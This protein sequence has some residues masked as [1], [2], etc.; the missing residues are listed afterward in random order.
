MATVTWKES[1][2][3]RSLDAWTRYQREHDVSAH[4][5]RTAGIDPVS[6]Q[7]WFGDSIED[8]SAQLQRH[9]ATRPLYFLRIGQDHY[10]R[11]GGHR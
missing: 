6:G 11:K 9:G 10:F 2:T 5:G 7:V 3:Q 1:D 8:I 4:L